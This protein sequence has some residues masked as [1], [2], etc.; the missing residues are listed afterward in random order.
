MT[1]LDLESFLQLL[2]ADL[3]AW[4]TLGLVVVVLGL[5]TWTSWGSRRALRKCLVL[6]IAAHVGIVLYSS[7]IPIVMTVLRNKP[8]RVDDSSVKV[9]LAPTQGGTLA[10]Q[11]EVKGRDGRSARAAALW[12]R[13]GDA[14]GLADPSAKVARP[15]ER[16]PLDEALAPTLGPLP[17]E[18]VV[19]EVNPPPPTAP[20]NTATASTAE[21][22]AA[23]S[24][25]PGDPV[26]VA[27]PSAPKPAAPAPG[28]L[29]GIASR[30]RPNR[31]T[32][33]G[34]GEIA[35]PPIPN[36][37]PTAAPIPAVPGPLA[38][39]A[40]SQPPASPTAPPASVALGDPSDIAAPKI[41]PRTL[42]S[43]PGARDV[44]A[45][46]DARA[47]ARREAVSPGVS[48]LTLLNPNR[49]PLTPGR[50]T[51]IPPTLTPASSENGMGSPA[52]TGSPG[53]LAPA[54][55][56]A[57][58][59]GSN[60]ASSRLPSTP[61]PREGLP[62]L[63]ARRQSRPDREATL[64]ALNERRPGGR[65]VANL[66]GIGPTGTPGLPAIA[67]GTVGLTRLPTEVPAVYRS[68]LDPNRFARALRSGASRESEQ[69]VE[70]ALDWL[71]RHQDADG[72]WDGGTA[73]YKDGTVAEGD[74]DYTAHCP[75][76]DICFGECF[77]W[78]ADSAV[79]GLALL[80]YLGAGYTHLNGQYADTVGRGLGYLRSV[81]KAD[82]DLRGRSQAV[83]MYC[84][85]MATLA[86]C[87]AYAL[88]GDPKLR[89]PVEKAVDF[90]V[91]CRAKD[92][93]AW[94][95]A[96]GAPV[97][98]TS[99][100][101]W[102]VMV[103]KSA[104]EVGIP[105]Q[106]TTKQGVL[107]WLSKVA[108]GPSNGLARYQPWEKVTPT[109]TAEAWVC[110]QFLGVGGP[111]ASSSEAAQYLLQY[112]P[113]RGQFNLYYLY[114]GTLAL[115]QHGGDAWTRWNAQVRDEILRRQRPSG[116]AAGSWD[117][118]ESQYGTHGGRI[119]CTALAT[120]SLE[121]YYRYLRL[122]ESPSTPR[123]A[124]FAPAN[125]SPR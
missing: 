56:A 74:D 58:A 1:G 47:R 25:A 120:L 91:K 71:R 85:A 76:G 92:G 78:E 51:V 43:S 46:P 53:P 118:D 64:L 124:E 35:R 67:G 45:D 113:N 116:H 55:V 38:T 90:L 26:D 29:I 99:I 5:L 36:S 70:R 14:A 19:L 103:L 72:R 18:S 80:A 49:P 111:G 12:D 66:P 81:Q 52:Q 10:S 24:V 94:R 21:P 86:L 42:D 37:T 125:R 96:P 93:L 95:Y 69:A 34:P 41:G 83:G 63:D 61:A 39:D 79:T 77:Y 32:A 101:G 28:E 22:A 4:A 121:V 30:L 50:P 108:D 112:G 57:D 8:A 13:A 100:L 104:Q 109:M 115:Y 3:G 110:R 102:V 2:R 44:V 88:T 87:E 117:P 107:T 106:P 16:G 119:Y 15:D 97:G 11:N 68:R 105:I 82:G 60:P 40:T 31:G 122:Y 7:S 75:A 27:K 65:T 17:P 9:Q 54:T 20:A 98:D 73:K 89:A 33:S 114:Y 6:S 62:D 48:P 84:H 23:P 123:A 59:G